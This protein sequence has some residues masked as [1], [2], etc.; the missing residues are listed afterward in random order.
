MKNL[1][2]TDFVFIDFHFSRILEIKS[3]FCASDNS[4]LAE[5][6]S[7]VYWLEDKIA[8]PVALLE[9]GSVAQKFQ[10]LKRDQRAP[11]EYNAAALSVLFSSS[12]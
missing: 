11:R 1:N 12:T 9:I 10:V 5:S 8:F 3:N 7:E 4:Y 2:N 6:S